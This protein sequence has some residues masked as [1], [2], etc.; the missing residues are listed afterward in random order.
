MGKMNVREMLALKEVEKDIGSAGAIH[1]MS[2][3]DN[4]KALW[5]SHKKDKIDDICVEYKEKGGYAE[6]QKEHYPVKVEFPDCVRT[7]KTFDKEFIFT[8][9][10]SPKVAF[11]HIDTDYD[12]SVN[13]Q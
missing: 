7:I 8:R 11:R 13:S 1:Q 3:R 6:W 12:R 9:I 10:S 5:P 2:G 4:R